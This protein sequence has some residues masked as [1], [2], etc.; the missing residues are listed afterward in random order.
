MKLSFQVPVKF[1]GIHFHNM[2]DKFIADNDSFRAA[3]NDSKQ[4]RVDAF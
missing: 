4:F 2:L 1:D 3:K